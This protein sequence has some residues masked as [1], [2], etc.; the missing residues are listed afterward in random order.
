MNLYDEVKFPL[1]PKNALQN[2][3]T[4]ACAVMSEAEERKWRQG[5]ISFLWEFGKVLR[6]PDAS[7]ATAS[8]FFHRYYARYAFENSYA[9]V[10]MCALSCLFLAAKIEGTAIKIRKFC[11]QYYQFKGQ[12][13]PHIDG[14]QSKKVENIITEKEMKLLE[15]NE[16]TLWI[17]HPY[18]YYLML[19]RHKLQSIVDPKSAKTIA[20][21]GYQLI[22]RSFLTNMCLS[23]SPKEIAVIVLDMLAKRYKVSIPKR[24][25]FMADWLSEFCTELTKEDVA[26]VTSEIL[27]V[28]S[29][30]KVAS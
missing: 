25:P 15:S 17:E 30:T 11:E 23:Y 5:I 22:T 27:A 14:K 7:I 9:D 19:I 21:E 2:T 26:L 6:L 3:P 29:K 16:F 18:R 4:Q 12:S 28:S 1:F 20:L 10:E 24:I 13:S 8:V